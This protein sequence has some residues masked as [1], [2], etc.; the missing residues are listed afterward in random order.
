M[1]YTFQYA[2]TKR[3]FAITNN[4]LD[5][6]IKDYKEWP[7]HISNTTMEED[8]YKEIY[9]YYKTCMNEFI[10]AVLT[11]TERTELLNDFSEIQRK[12]QLIISIINKNTEATISIVDN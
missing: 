10:M 6:S 2:Q 8:F 12:T 9:P 11:D 5:Q 3:I 7:K 1:I 4:L